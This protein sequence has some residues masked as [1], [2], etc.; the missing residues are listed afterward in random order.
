MSSLIRSPLWA[1][2]LSITAPKGVRFFRL[3]PSSFLSRR[4]KV[5]SLRSLPVVLLVA[6][7]FFGDASGQTLLDVLFEEFVRGLV[8][9]GRPSPP[10]F[11]GASDTLRWALLE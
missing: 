5:E 7:P 3:K 9:L 10:P 8:G 1:Q 6:T 4:S 2:R 11:L